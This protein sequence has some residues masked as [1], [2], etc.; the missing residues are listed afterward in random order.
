[1]FCLS[2]GQCG[3]RWQVSGVPDLEN[4]AAKQH[5]IP[6]CHLSLR[7]NQQDELSKGTTQ[8]QL[9]QLFMQV[10]TQCEVTSGRVARIKMHN[11]FFQSQGYEGKWSITNVC[12]SKFSHC[13][14]FSL[15]GFLNCSAQ[16]L[17][18]FLKPLKGQTKQSFVV[19]SSLKEYSTPW[20]Y[21]IS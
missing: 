16:C 14:Q 2:C 7:D 20:N 19:F 13:L 17:G 18:A 15:Y 21:V 6:Q 10:T 5:V 11:L 3:G 9:L 12:M 4:K 1:M 8:E